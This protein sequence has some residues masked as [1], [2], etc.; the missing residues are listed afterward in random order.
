VKALLLGLLLGLL[1]AYPHLAVAAAVP[2]LAW[3]LGQP[4]VWAFA[5]GLIARPCTARRLTRSTT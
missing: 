2:A 1:A 3:L 4:V 5:A